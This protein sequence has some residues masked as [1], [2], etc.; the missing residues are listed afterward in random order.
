MPAVRAQYEALVKTLADTKQGDLRRHQEEISAYLREEIASRYY[1]QAGR[2]QAELAGDETV[3]TAI[4]ILLDQDRYRSLLR[5]KS[6]EMNDAV[7]E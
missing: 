6:A 3:E 2:A 4:G 5:P 7:E 1:Y